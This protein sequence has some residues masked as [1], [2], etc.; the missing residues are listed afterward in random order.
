MDLRSGTL[1]GAWNQ[2]DG[3]FFRALA[4]QKRFGA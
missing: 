3:D 1:V 2:C 4:G